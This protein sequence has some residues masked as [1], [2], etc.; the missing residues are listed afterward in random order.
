MLNLR[1]IFTS[2]IVVFVISLGFTILAALL[3]GVFGVKSSDAMWETLAYVVAGSE[4]LIILLLVV[5]A[6]NPKTMSIDRDL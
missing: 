6:S 3:E 1:P 2:A 4:A 5:A